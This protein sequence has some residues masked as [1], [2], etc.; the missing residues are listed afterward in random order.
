[1]RNCVQNVLQ[2]VV[3]QYHN[4][5]LSAE[6]PL[7]R[8]C[9]TRGDETPMELFIMSHAGNSL[10]SFQTDLWKHL[11]TYPKCCVSMVIF[12]ISS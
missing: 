5:Q 9:E 12:Y 6:L 7:C 1:M 10:G 3:H 2:L 11:E 8:S 4:T